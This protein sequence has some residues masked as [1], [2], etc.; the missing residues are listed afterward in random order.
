VHNPGYT[1]TNV[2][3]T[4]ETNLYDASN[5]NIVWSGRSATFNPGDV[6]DVINPTAKLIVQNLID[7]GLVQPKK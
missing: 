5:E 4:L 2:T 3:V 1:Y 7:E 6:R